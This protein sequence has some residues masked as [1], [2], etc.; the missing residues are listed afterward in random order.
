[1]TDLFSV[2]S[3][4]IMPCHYHVMTCRVMSFHVLCVSV[5]FGWVV[6]RMPGRVESI[7][8]LLACPYCSALPFVG[9]VFFVPLFFLRLLGWFQFL[10]PAPFFSQQ[11][12]SFIQAAKRLPYCGPAL[13]GTA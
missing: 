4:R 6:S 13:Q 8:L 10:L 11:G 2:V 7:V 5:F 12:P 3:C 1:M 9:S